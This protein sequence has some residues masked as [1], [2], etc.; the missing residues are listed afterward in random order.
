VGAP[1]GAQAAGDMPALARGFAVAS[2]DTG[3]QGQ[4]GFDSAFMQDQQAALDFAFV[5]IGRVAALAKEIVAQHYGKPAEHAYFAGCSTGGREAMLMAQRFPTYFDGIVA[6]APA[7]RTGYSNLGT[8]SVAV[9]LNQVAPKDASGQPIPGQ[10]FSEADKKT[11]I[12]GLLNACDDKDGLKDG[13][14]FNTR[15]CTFDPKALVCSGAKKDG[16]LSADQANAIAKAFSGPKDSKGRQVYPAFPFDTGITATGGGIPG[17]LS[18][19]QSPLGPPNRSLQQDVDAEALAQAMNAQG[20]IGDTWSWTNL[21]TFS[22]HGGKLLFFHGM[23]DPWFSANDTIEYYE[24]LAASNGGAEQVQNFSRLF[25]SPGMGH[26]GGGQG[27]LD[28]FDLLSA[29]VDWVEKGTAPASVVATSRAQPGRSR[30]LCA[31]PKSAYYK[32][33]GDQ[34]NA[35]SF[36]CR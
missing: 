35:S 6:G 23:S 15:A 7:M 20:I 28:S 31:Y 32:G 29:V 27:A 19:G 8:R 14:I 10:A 1:L 18:P 30:P 13:M 26:C 16:C 17:L 9:A 2:T 33:Q 21:N 3:H 12:D 11:V 22:G 34:Q 24:K 25:L 4:G 36:E 5:A